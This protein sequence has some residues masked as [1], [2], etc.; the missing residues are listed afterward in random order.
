MKQS[1]SK[2]PFITIADGKLNVKLPE[3]SLIDIENRI[4]VTVTD[5]ESAPVKDMPVTVTDSTEKSESNL[6]DENG[7][8]TVPP[9]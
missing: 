1:Q 9:D 8:A 2:T 7:K 6:T 3:G 5:S 4:T